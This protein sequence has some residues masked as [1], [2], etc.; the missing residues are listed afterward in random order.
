[1]EG[2]CTGEHGVG[3]GKIGSMRLE[4]GDDVID[5]MRDIKKVFDPENLMNPGKVVAVMRTSLCHCLR[6]GAGRRGRS[7]TP[8][9]HRK[10]A[11]ARAEE[12]APRLNLKLDQPA[13]YYTSETP[14]EKGRPRTSCRRSATARSR[15][16]ARR[17]RV[18]DNSFSYPK[19]STAR[20]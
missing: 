6:L 15:W 14:G 20:K 11:R 5:V 13:R 19:D 3:L 18:A 4:L 12:P 10:S 9:Q 2:T 7:P 1:M 8:A 16:S 17:P